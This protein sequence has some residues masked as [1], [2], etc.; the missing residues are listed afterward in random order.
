MPP[1]FE[2][3]P[4]QAWYYRIFL[5]SRTLVILLQ[6]DLV[7]NDEPKTLYEV[8]YENEDTSIFTRYS[9]PRRWTLSLITKFNS[10]IAS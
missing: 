5:K 4:L 9:I 8:F 1:R 6:V 10:L 7:S 2:I 3:E